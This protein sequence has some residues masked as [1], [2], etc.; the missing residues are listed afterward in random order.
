MLGFRELVVIAVVAVVIFGT[1]RL[2]NLGKD[3]GTSIKG[4]KDAMK[5]NE[6]TDNIAAQADSTEKPEPKIIEG[7]VTRKS[8]QDAP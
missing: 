7:E 4:F 5:E 2:R 1:S 6:P 8:E 3:L